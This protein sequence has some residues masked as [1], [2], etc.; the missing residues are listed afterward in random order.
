M[1]RRAIEISGNFGNAD[2][3]AARGSAQIP[4]ESA[5]STLK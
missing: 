1:L 4:A 2:R 5:T 3:S